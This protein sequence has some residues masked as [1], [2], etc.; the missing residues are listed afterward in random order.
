M[1]II[2]NPVENPKSKYKFELT[3]MSGDADA[4]QTETVLVDE[5]DRDLERFAD[6]CLA[7]DNSSRSGPREACYK[8]KDYDYFEEAESQECSEETSFC[9][10]Y[11]ERGDCPQRF[12]NLKVTY[13]NFKGV[14]Y[15]VELKASQ[16]VEKE[17]REI[18]K[19]LLN[20]EQREFVK[21][22]EKKLTKNENN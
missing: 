6:F 22:I 3:F 13:F 19:I 11:D 8:I 12:V 9:W 15:E 4:Y 5:K 20:E 7:C 18:C 14:E 1:I 16:F 21:V 17:P 10:P 2:K